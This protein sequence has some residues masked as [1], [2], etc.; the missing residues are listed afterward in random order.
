MK[1]PYSV[2]II[3]PVYNEEKTIAK[4]IESVKESNTLGL[5]KEIIVVNDG[6]TDKTEKVLKK[7][8]DRSVRIYHQPYNKGKGAALRHGFEMSTGD[9][10]LVQDADL[11]YNPK[12]YP[13]LLEPLIKGKAKVVYGSRMLTHSKMH[14]GGWIF[15]IGG[16]FINWLTNVLYNLEITDEATG[17]KVFEAKTLATIPLVCKKFD[18]C[19]EITAKIA[20]RNIP[21]YEVEISYRGR[22]VAEGKKINWKDGLHAVWTLLKYKFVE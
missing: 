12:D 5:T 1:K 7:L 22:K 17:Y 13:K 4:I 15:Y 19:P 3:I 14:H 8:K 10:I 2:S 20:K 16:Q 11:E 9:I 6:S 18:F 21:I